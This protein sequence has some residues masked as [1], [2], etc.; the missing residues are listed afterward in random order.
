MRLRGI[1][2]NVRLIASGGRR[3]FLLQNDLARF[4]QNA[5]ERETISQIQSD[6]KLSLLQNFIPRCLQ[7]LIFFIAG[8]LFL[9]LEHVEHWERIASRWETGL[10]I[11]SD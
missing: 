5:V 10:L 11:P 9:C 4:I 7:V 2:S 1:F 6:G 8:L 3:H